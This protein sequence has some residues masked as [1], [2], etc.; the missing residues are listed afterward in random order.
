MPVPVYTPEGGVTLDW[1]ADYRLR[2]RV[3]G[4]EERGYEVVIEGNA[5]GFE[6]L[7]RH[8]LALAQPEVPPGLHFH[9]EDSTVLDAPSAAL[10]LD[11]EDDLSEYDG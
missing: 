9:M 4:N 6:S 2:V 7:A 11:R 10:V 8:A 1:V 5:A 3:L